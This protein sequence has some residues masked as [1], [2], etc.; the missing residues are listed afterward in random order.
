M[1]CS[2]FV[3]TQLQLL[4][5]STLI[6]IIIACNISQSNPVMMNDDFSPYLAFPLCIWLICFV[7]VFLLA[8]KAAILPRKRTIPMVYQL[9]SDSRKSSTPLCKGNKI[10]ITKETMLEIRST[11]NS[12]QLMQQ[13][14]VVFGIN[15][16]AD[17]SKL[18]YSTL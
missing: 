7:H 8:K 17:A 14:M 1:L 11:F 9:G 5:T 16:S 15:T 10:M 3:S 6:M 4:T 18:L 12:V 2:H 13:L